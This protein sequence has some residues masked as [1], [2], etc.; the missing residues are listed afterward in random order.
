[1]E[2]VGLLSI[3]LAVPAAVGW[4]RLVRSPNLRQW[5]LIGVAFGLL[6]IF[7]LVTGGKSYY[8]APMYPVLLAAG[9]LWF[10]GLS[11][12]GRR[13][14]IGAAAV[15]IFIGLFISLPLL[16]ESAVSNVDATG[17]LS[18]TVGWP[19]LVD[20][21]AAVYETIPAEQRATTAIFTGS[22]GEAGAIDV[23]GPDLDLPAASSAHNNHWL[24]GPPERHGPVIGVGQTG[25]MLR[26]ICPG[27]EQVGVISNPYGVENEE[28][29][30]PLFLCLDPRG[31]LADIWDEAKHF[32]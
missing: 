10:E 19:D 23:L 31:Q 3:V 30:L 5:Q 17:E 7:F 2:Q 22:Y 27:V 25:G 15:G 11:E 26:Q 13:V 9:S 14:M 32:N 18:E 8:V 29:G 6:F 20:Q 12:L 4:W 21:V 1:L 24:W 16:S 28:A